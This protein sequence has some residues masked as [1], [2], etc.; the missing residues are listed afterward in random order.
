MSWNQNEETNL[1]NVAK[2]TLICELTDEMQMRR[3]LL[4]VKV[5]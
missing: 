5:L 2:G 1:R 4:A 3:D